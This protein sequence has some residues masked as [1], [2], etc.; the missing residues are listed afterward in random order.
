MRA[1]TGSVSIFISIHFFTPST[2]MISGSLSAP[3]KKRPRLCSA[4]GQ[5][6]SVF[7]LPI[8]E[9]ENEEAVPGGNGQTQGQLREIT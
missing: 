5:S 6:L 9:Q 8:Q 7:L 1:P 2:E 4:R 3:E